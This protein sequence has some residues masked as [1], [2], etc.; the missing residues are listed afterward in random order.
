MGGG[1]GVG[2][3]GVGLGWEHRG[4]GWG[5]SVGD[6]SMGGVAGVG[7]WGVWLGWEC[8]GWEHGGCGW[9]GSVGGVAGV[10]AW[11]VGWEH[12]SWDGSIGVGAVDGWLGA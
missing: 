9:G 10:G 11:E 4:C 1:A 6:G 2:A 7:A 12:W 3:W 8:G 5:G